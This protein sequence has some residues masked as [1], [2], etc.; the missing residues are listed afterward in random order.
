MFIMHKSEKKHGSS[1][2][3]SPHFDEY[4]TGAV[5]FYSADSEN[6]RKVF[7]YF[8]GHVD[9]EDYLADPPQ[10][11]I[12][13]YGRLQIGFYAHNGWLLWRRPPRI[14]DMWGFIS[15]NMNNFMSLT[16]TPLDQRIDTMRVL[17]R[18]AGCDKPYLD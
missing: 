10:Q 15:P 1:K 12:H 11:Y 17:V 3:P 8:A 14:E 16:G 7:V 4:C 18:C 13:T 9:D 5:W 6:R 2:F